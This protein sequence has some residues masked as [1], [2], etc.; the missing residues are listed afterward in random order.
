MLINTI[1]DYVTRLLHKEQKELLL[2]FSVFHN[3]DHV[4]NFEQRVDVKEISCIYGM[5]AISMMWIIFGHTYMWN[6]L[7]PLDNPIILQ[8]VWFYK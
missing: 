8:E 2:L 7:A 4:F 6:L 5:K 3:L 1:Y